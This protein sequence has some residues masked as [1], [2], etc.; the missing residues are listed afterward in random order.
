[1]EQCKELCVSESSLKSSNNNELYLDVQ[2][3]EMAQRVSKMLSQSTM[4]PEHFRGNIGNCM[5]ALNFASRTGLDVFMVMQKLYVIHG[6]PGIEAQL[7]IALINKSGRFT[8]L[9]FRMKGTPGKDLE[10]TCYATEKSTGE[11][12]TQ[13]VT[14]KIVDAEGWNK[15][16]GSKWQ[17]MPQL[18]I[19]YRSA[20]FFGR[21]YCPEA[22]LGMMTQEELYDIHD[23]KQHN[24]TS[25]ADRLKT[26]KPIPAIPEAITM[27]DQFA[28]AE[29]KAVSNPLHTTAEW[30]KY[31]EACDIDPDLAGTF[32]EPTTVEDC[33]KAVGAIN[34]ALNEQNT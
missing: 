5:I 1:M 29:Q 18:M 32:P 33:I 20:A 26:E 27:E 31:I 30:A 25:I 13:T 4:V 21:L 12:C 19:Q 8:P 11:E 16:A 6:K 17:T 23:P 15:K 24:V 9:K 22:L 14:W 28:Q 2:K 7:M 34:Q 10:C 3:F